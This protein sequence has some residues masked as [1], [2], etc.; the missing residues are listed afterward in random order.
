MKKFALVFVCILMMAG[1]G[2]KEV[3]LQEVK[4]GYWDEAIGIKD[5]EWNY[6][7][8]TDNEVYFQDGTEWFK[9]EVLSAFNGNFDMI[10]RDYLVSDN[11]VYYHSKGQDDLSMILVETDL[12][13]TKVFYDGHSV[14]WAMDVNGQFHAFTNQAGGA[15]Q[16]M[17]LP[18]QLAETGVKDFAG[19]VYITEAGEAREFVW[20]LGENNRIADEQYD[21]SL[22]SISALALI[23][24]GEGKALVVCNSGDIYVSAHSKRIATIRDTVLAG[25]G[26]NVIQTEYGYYYLENTTA[27]PANALN[28]YKDRVI[29][30]GQHGMVPVMVLDDG[31]VYN[32]K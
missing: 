29:S 6:V 24:A 25:Y 18:A 21:D 31:K 22:I 12:Q 3:P 5:L 30:I 1:C 14:L 13:F 7:V 16:E 26:Y 20:L 15:F 9:D 10:G 8:T 32:I 17:V 27:T 23:D 19:N 4:L 11:T 28:T 2:S